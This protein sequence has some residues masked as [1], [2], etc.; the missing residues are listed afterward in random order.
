MRARL[1]ER[2]GLRKAELDVSG[3]YVQLQCGMLHDETPY[4]VRG[5]NRRRFAAF[6]QVSGRPL[7]GAPAAALTMSFG[8]KF[9]AP[10][11]LGA[12]ASRCSKCS[13][14]TACSVAQSHAS[15]RATLSRTMTHWPPGCSRH[16][17]RPRTAPD[18]GHFASL[19]C[20]FRPILLIP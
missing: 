10:G 11:D 12:A 2:Q 7:P 14:T 6:D 13:L 1:R 5:R 20:D 3:R 15:V 9:G 8:R 19:A 18:R 17:R 4:D 16:G